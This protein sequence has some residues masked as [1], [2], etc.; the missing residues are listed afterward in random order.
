MYWRTVRR[1]WPVYAAIVLLV[2]FWPI[3]FRTPARSVPTGDGTIDSLLASND[4]VN[5]ALLRKD[6]EAIQGELGRSADHRVVHPLAVTEYPD[7]RRR[8]YVVT[9]FT[10][11]RALAYLRHGDTVKTMNQKRGRGYLL[12]PFGPIQGYHHWIR[13]EGVWYLTFFDGDPY[14]AGS[15]RTRPTPTDSGWVPIQTQ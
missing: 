14:Y 13:K 5:A 10:E 1:L 12:L 9:T 4:R 8:G 3:L 15:G 6:W 11:Y 2:V 7:A